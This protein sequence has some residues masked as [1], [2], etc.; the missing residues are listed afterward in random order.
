MK[1]KPYLSTFACF[2]FCLVLAFVITIFDSTKAKATNT[3]KISCGKIISDGDIQVFETVECGK[4]KRILSDSDDRLTVYQKEVNL[5]KQFK[6]RLK[7]NI[8]ETQ[9]EIKQKFT[10]TYD[11]KEKAE[12]LPQDMSSNVTIVKWKISPLSKISFDDGICT[13]SNQYRVYQKNLVGNYQYMCDGFA[14]IFCDCNGEIGI[15]SDVR[16]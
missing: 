11:K 1:R 7:E 9:A 6:R 3:E 10:F 12:I 14:D 5:K 4:E 16:L 15:N 13:V 2:V 8:Y